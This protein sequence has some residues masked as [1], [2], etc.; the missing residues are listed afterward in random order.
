[1]YQREDSLGYLINQAARLTH[2]S[3]RLQLG[4]DSPHPSY[5]PVMLWLREEDGQTQAALARRA[6]IEQPSM[7]E[8]VKRMERD[9][10]LIRKPDPD[11]RRRQRLFLSAKA[12][13]Y[14]GKL[15]D[16]LEQHNAAIN[17][18]V[19]SRDHAVFVRVLRQMIA[20]MEGAIA[21][22]EGDGNR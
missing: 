12:K 8:L 7:A 9:G 3:M 13:R 17:H 10:L 16:W 6:G 21:K 11:D 5:L 20:N 15:L 2:K 19:S 14:S 18:D 4:P 22:T 1:M